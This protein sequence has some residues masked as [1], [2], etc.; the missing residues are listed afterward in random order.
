MISPLNTQ[1]NNN[2]RMLELAC[3]Q[4]VSSMTGLFCLISN[5]SCRGK[6]DQTHRMESKGICDNFC[7]LVSDKCECEYLMI[8]PL[9]ICEKS[10]VYCRSH[11]GDTHWLHHI[12]QPS[13]QYSII[14]DI[15]V[16]FF[17]NHSFTCS[18]TLILT[19][20]KDVFCY[21]TA[22]ICDGNNLLAG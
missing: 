8:T 17:V 15:F 6:A 18:G 4:V 10:Q 19:D 5:D 1:V 3:F 13:E 22:A 7:F 12:Y 14:S 2:I 11:P 21:Y 20:V 9:A 16:L